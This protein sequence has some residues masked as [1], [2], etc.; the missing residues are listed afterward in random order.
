VNVKV[1]R[2]GLFEFHR[3]AELITIGRDAAQKALP[4]LAQLLE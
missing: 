4:D 3:A 1:G 2:I